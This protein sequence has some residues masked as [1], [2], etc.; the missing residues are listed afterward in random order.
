MQR[1]ADVALVA[2]KLTKLAPTK[3][4]TPRTVGLG[5]ARLDGPALERE[6]LLVA[7]L[8]AKSRT[9][10]TRAANALFAAGHE[11]SAEQEHHLQLLEHLDEERVRA[12]ILALGAI[13]D[14]EPARHRPVLEQRLRRI[15]ETAEDRETRAS[16]AALRRSIR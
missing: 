14:R 7:L 11:P 2:P 6:R 12:A 4:I 8:N 1:R 16:A 10:V 5:T 15:E 3:I 13:L 9:D